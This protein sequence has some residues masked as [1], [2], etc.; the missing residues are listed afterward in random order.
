[1]IFTV[2]MAIHGMRP[3]LCHIH[4]V[5]IAVMGAMAGWYLVCREQVRWNTAAWILS[6]WSAGE[7][8]LTPG[9]IIACLDVEII[10]RYGVSQN[11]G[12]PK[13]SILMGFS[14]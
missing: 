13:S 5:L 7:V 6:S 9:Q 3:Y 1:M 10:G 4:I 12:T 8:T 14:L 11:R 2:L